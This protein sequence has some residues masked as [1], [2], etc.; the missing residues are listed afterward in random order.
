LTQVKRVCAGLGHIA[1]MQQ[2]RSD[3][4][5]VPPCATP[6][7]ALL[8]RF[9]TS[10]PD[11]LCYPTP[12]RFV[13]AFGPAQYARALGQRLG[14]GLT[15]SRAPL[16]L[17]VTFPT[18]GPARDSETFDAL[19][20]ELDMQL[21][22][23]GRGQSLVQLHLGSSTP[24]FHEAGRLSRLMQLLRFGFEFAADI[25]CSIEIDPRQFPQDRLAPIAA[26]GFDRLNLCAQDVVPGDRV[27]RLA[28]AARACGFRSVSVDLRHGLPQASADSS[29]SMLAQ[30][31]AI[32]PDRVTLC[33]PVQA[34][35]SSRARKRID[36]RALPDATQWAH[37]LSTAI[38]ALCSQG[39][40]CIGMDQF[41][42]PGDALAVAKR[43]GRLHRGL[44]GYSTRPDGDLIGLGVAS[45]GK[46]GVSYGQNARA[47]ADYRDA[48]R[49]GDLPLARGLARSRDDRVRRSVIMALV[50]QGRL[51]Y[52]SIEAA[53]LVD[54]RRQFSVELRRLEPL[55]EHGLLELQADGLQITPLGVYFVRAVAM[56]F[57]RPLQADL[58]REHDSHF[59]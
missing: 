25:E 44:L 31:L 52:E 14:A 6:D 3:G 56:A 2:T 51:D 26:L 36:P 32:R 59:I 18:V 1:S 54:F 50:C 5:S 4:S 48:L 29:H 49:A 23:L 57:D 39:Y 22:L 53:H 8:R 30:T 12:D 17:A 47:L 11:Y 15:A 19:G 33:G 27:A 34:P 9:S 38:E 45:V 55:A 10:G 24:T 28:S 42:L 20:C 21:E 58:A 46:V 7:E 13:E 16:A 37:S 43:Q 35:G 40:V 41:V